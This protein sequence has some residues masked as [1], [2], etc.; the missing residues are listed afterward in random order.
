MSSV[1]N[2]LMSLGTG[3]HYVSLYAH[4]YVVLKSQQKNVESNFEFLELS[5][6]FWEIKS[7]L[8]VRFNIE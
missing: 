8:S 1:D 4:F 5:G 7:D 3:K 2:V 6:F